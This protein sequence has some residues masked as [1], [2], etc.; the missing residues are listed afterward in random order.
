MSYLFLKHWNDIIALL[1]PF[2][3]WFEQNL[4][5]GIFYYFLIFVVLMVLAIPT[6]FLILAGSII[7]GRFFGP[8]QGFFLTLLFVVTFASLGGMTGF[9]L[10]RLFLRK[11]IRRYLTRKIKLFR[12]IDYGLKNNA[13]KMVI[14]MRMAPLIPNNIFHYVMAVTSIRI[15]DYLIGNLVGMLP[16]T[17]VSIYVGVHLNNIQDIQQ[18]NYGL[19]PWQPVIISIGV[20]FIVII[21]ALMISFSKSELQRIL[22][23]D[24]RL[25]ES[26][27]HSSVELSQQRSPCED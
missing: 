14:L 7:F 20:V 2:F 21:T 11:F 3:L 23:E 8:T 5:E 4:F 17:S 19:G 27:L 13:L 1:E 15:R 6:D 26:V 18:G 25:L 9:F 12:A 10:G 16:A 22:Q 24:K